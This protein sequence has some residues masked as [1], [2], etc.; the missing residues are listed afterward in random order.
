VGTPVDYDP[1]PAL[2]AYRGPALWMLAGR[3]SLAPSADTL[4]IL[5]GMQP[6]HPDLD[7]VMFPTAD[8]GIIEFEVKNGERVETRFS[9]GYFQLVVDWILFKETKPRVAGPTVYAGKA[10]TTAP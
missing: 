2:D 1:L 7:V 6:K 9:E 5:R 8:H 10:K 3:D 4:R